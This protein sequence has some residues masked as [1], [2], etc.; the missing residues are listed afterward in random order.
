MF[1]KSFNSKSLLGTATLSLALFSATAFAGPGKSGENPI[2]DLLTGS[3]K[4]TLF[5]PTDDAFF[6]LQ[7]V[8]GVPEE[9]RAPAVTCL[10][11]T[12]LKTEGAV[13]TLQVS[14]QCDYVG[15][16]YADQEFAAISSESSALMV[17]F[18]TRV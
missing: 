3:D 8:L 17:L 9:D 14:L 1:S 18:S 13:V 12:V 10:V 16:K 6:A 15:L 4:L 11:D 2:V 5:A 7:G